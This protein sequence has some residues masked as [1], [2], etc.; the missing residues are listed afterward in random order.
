MAK[1]AVVA[2]DG[3]EHSLRQG[4]SWR[5][6]GEKGLVVLQPARPVVHWWRRDRLLAGPKHQML[7]PRDASA[8][9]A[10]AALPHQAVVRVN[11]GA[12]VIDS[13]AGTLQ[14]GFAGVQLELQPFVQKGA[15]QWL[16]QGMNH[17]ELLSRPEVTKQ[18]VRW[19]AEPAPGARRLIRTRP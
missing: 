18:L 4:G 9:G 19:L 11:N 3:S 7:E 10:Y 14:H 13:L 16:A 17:M 2:V 1:Q 15:I 6:R 8:Q 5:L 12:K